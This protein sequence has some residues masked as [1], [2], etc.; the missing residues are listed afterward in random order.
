[1][2]NKI[3]ATQENEMDGWMGWG[4]VEHE[5]LKNRNQTKADR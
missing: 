2:P 5:D 1:M 3:H 4:K